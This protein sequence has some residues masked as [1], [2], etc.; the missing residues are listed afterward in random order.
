MAMLESDGMITLHA[1]THDTTITI[2]N[3]DKYQF[4]R[5][6]NEATDEATDLA[7]DL[8]TDEAQR[9]KDNK[10]INKCSNNKPKGSPLVPIVE[11]M[12]EELQPVLWK[13]IQHRNT[14]K[15]PVSTVNLE[16]LIEKLVDISHGDTQEAIGILKQSMANGWKIIKPLE[17]QN[18]TVSLMD[19]IRAGEFDE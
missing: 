11:S 16:A 7:T 5:T 15:A 2:E 10:G 9:N 1:T 4:K 17:K 14:L 13:F 19:R 18:N 8:A 6:T 3:Y 12:P